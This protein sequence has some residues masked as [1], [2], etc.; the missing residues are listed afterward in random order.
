NPAPAAAFAGRGTLLSG[1][2][3][4]PRVLP[5]LTVRPVPCARQGCRQLG[6]PF[7]ANPE[8]RVLAFAEWVQVTFAGRATIGAA[9]RSPG[10]IDTAPTDGLERRAATSMEL[11]SRYGPLKGVEI[12]VGD[13]G[14]VFRRWT[15]AEPA[16]PQRARHR[17]A[18]LHLV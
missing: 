7:L 9:R 16:G 15:V 2:R 5:L 10:A 8:V 4:R 6:S 12:D 17:R 18:S 13:S 3:Q 1:F 14:L 11:G